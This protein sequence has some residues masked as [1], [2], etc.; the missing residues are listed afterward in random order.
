[1]KPILFSA[2]MVRAILAGQKT[3]TRRV[4]KFPEGM[5][6]HYAPC[7]DRDYIYYPCGIMRPKY[8]VG[9]VLWVR[10]TWGS[11]AADNPDSFNCDIFFRA[12]YPDGARTYEW[13]ELDEFGE[14]IICD[15]PKWHPSMFMPKE[16]ARIFLRVTAVRAE[17]LQDITV[18]DVMAEGLPCDNDINNPD[19][20]THEGIRNWNLTYAQFLFHELWD[21][22]NA[23]RGYGWDKN[24]WVW[25]YTFER[26]T[27][28]S[29]DCRPYP[30][31]DRLYG[32][33]IQNQ[34]E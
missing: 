28:S 19:P 17:R 34:G 14:K 27:P 24:P 4:I 6:G 16:A 29:I 11:Y 10:E 23:A 31:E 32:D 30:R 13:P 1:M 9:D 12:D 25:V 21:K 8:Q 33:E 22:L 15:L 20:Q 7:G 2:T 26:I 18:A 3:M 5:T